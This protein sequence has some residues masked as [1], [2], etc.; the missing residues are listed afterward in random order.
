MAPIA[1]EMVPGIVDGDLN[2]IIDDLLSIESRWRAGFREGELKFCDKVQLLQ[3][4][5][6]HHK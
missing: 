6:L 1:V 2:Q 5:P 4:A 3:V